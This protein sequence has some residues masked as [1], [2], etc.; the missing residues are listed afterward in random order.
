[1][2]WPRDLGKGAVLTIVALFGTTI[3]PYLFFWQSSQ[4]AE[5]IATDPEQKP[6]KA[7]R[8]RAARRQFRRIRVDTLLGMA[9]SNLIALAIM[10][11]TAA[12]L[13]MPGNHRDR[14]RRR[15][16]RR[17][18]ARSPGISPS[19]LFAV[20]IIGTGLLAVPVLAGSAAFAVGETPVGRSALN[21]KPQRGGAASTR[22]SSPRP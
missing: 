15:R 6:L 14:V 12:T 9:L 20:G 2:V 1:M 22:S 5:E 21:I 7:S 13:D 11:A 16:G 8:R 3:S 19:L 17:R 18:C 4:E 10:L